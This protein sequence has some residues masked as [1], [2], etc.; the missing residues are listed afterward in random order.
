MRS[1]LNDYTFSVQEIRILREI[2]SKNHLLSSIR[3][4]L[5]IKPNLLSH[6][7]EKLS[8]KSLVKCTKQSPSSMEEKA[9]RSAKYIYFSDLKHASFL[10][11]LLLKY[12]YVEWENILS[13]LGIE[14]LF[15]I[16]AR[17]NSNTES[18]SR[19]T[20][21]RYSKDFMS[22]GMIDADGD[23]YRI[24]PRFSL[25]SDFL[26]EYQHFIIQKMLESLPQPALALWQK[27]LE[28]L[29][30]LPKNLKIDNFGF[31]K[32]ATSRFQDFGLQLT[33]D[34]DTYFY[35]RSKKTIRI[36][37][38][39]LHTLLLETDSIRHTTY[40]LLL[41]KKESRRINREYLLKEASWFDLGLKVNA[42]YE[43]LRTRGVRS[44]STFPTWVE[45]VSKAIEYGVSV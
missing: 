13:G 24:S 9:E 18:F 17:H 39:I 36:E 23:F 20:F 7:L 42:M 32:T 44:G 45:F 6:Y 16:L 43:F 1:K 31:Q 21:W 29:I 11:Q 35:S 34:S 25:L 4:S 19:V 40:A 30:R 27:D 12:D 5:S 38:I 33:S 26:N 10:N 15:L 41:L 2:V 14:V 3:K 37:D 22:R 8:S 28:C